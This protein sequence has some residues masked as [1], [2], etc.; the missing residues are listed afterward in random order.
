MQE[1]VEVRL[2]QQQGQGILCL[3]HLLCLFSY[4]ALKGFLCLK[5]QGMHL[6]IRT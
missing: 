6:W 5:S 4:T 3:G 1:W 2:I